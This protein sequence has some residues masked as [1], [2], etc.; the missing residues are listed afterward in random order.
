MK[1]S[2]TK[3]LCDYFPLIIFFI[4]YKFARTPEPLITAT[5]FMIITTL[6]ALIFSYFLTKQIPMVALVSAIILT[7]FGGLTVFMKDEIFIKMK[8]T[9]INLLFATILFYGYFARKPLISYLLEGQIK[10][11]LQS[12]LILSRRWAWFFIF[13]AVLNEVIWRNFSTD[14]WVQFK[15]FGMMPIS[16][17][18]TIA[19]VPFMVREMKKLEK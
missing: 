7:I 8:P 5:I 19:Q 16:L 15:V 4:C 9:I 12:W 11:N 18:F 17:I 10:M 1:K 3:F 6:I 2:T 14:F 13:L